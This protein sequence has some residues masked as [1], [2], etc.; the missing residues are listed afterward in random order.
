MILGYSIAEK[1]HMIVAGIPAY[2]A[3]TS[4]AGTILRS[5][6]HVNR[7]IVVDDGSADYTAKIAESLGATVVSNARNVGKG[8][9]LRT[10][11]Q[12]ARQLEAD[13]LVTIDADGQHDPDDIPQIVEPILEHAADVVVGSRSA[14]PLIRRVGQ[15]ALDTA[16]D[17]RD[18]N[19]FLVDSQCGFRAYSRKAFNQLDFVESGMGAESESLKKAS[20]LGLTIQQVPIHVRYGGESDHSLHPVLHFSDVVS[21]L[22]KVALLK[23]PLRFLGIPAMVLVLVGLF[24]WFQILDTYNTTRQFAIGNALVASVVLIAGFFLGVGAIILLAIRLIVEGS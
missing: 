19:G 5:K 8:Q 20:E 7:I 22:A 16:T 24:W 13:V 17:V 10:I 2:N 3:E 11:F 9:A 1:P 4:I 14:A 15:R 6:K 21:A 23:R 18:V 12:L